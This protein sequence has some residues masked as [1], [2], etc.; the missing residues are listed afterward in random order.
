MLDRD[1]VLAHRSFIIFSI[2]YRMHVN[3]ELREFGATYL[4]PRWVEYLDRIVDVGW[5]GRWYYMEEAM[6]DYDI[7]E[8]EWK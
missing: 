6:V 3:S 7:N 2:I 4:R 8:D 1:G 5:L